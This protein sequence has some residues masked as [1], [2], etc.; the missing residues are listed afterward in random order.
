[1]V[2]LN[3]HFCWPSLRF[4]CLQPVTHNFLNKI[5]LKVTNKRKDKIM[6]TC[7]LLH[8]LLSWAAGFRGNTTETFPSPATSLAH[9]ALLPE[10]ESLKQGLFTFPA[11]VLRR[12]RD[13]LQPVALKLLPAQLQPA[14]ASGFILP[15]AE[16]C[17]LDPCVNVGGKKVRPFSRRVKQ[18]C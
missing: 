4:N 14:G 18:N 2:W 13:H 3:F 6:G 11:R 17:R 7:P 8:A 5:T 16:C 12:K 10:H 9:S 1:M 15:L